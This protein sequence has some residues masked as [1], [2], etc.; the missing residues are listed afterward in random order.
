MLFG[1]SHYAHGELREGEL[2]FLDGLNNGFVLTGKSIRV[3]ASSTCDLAMRWMPE[4]SVLKWLVWLFIGIPIA[5][6]ITIVI[7]LIWAIVLVAKLLFVRAPFLYHIGLLVAIATDLAILK[8][9]SIGE[10]NVAPSET[11]SI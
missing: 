8:A 1:D 10:A 2:T 7:S 9:M 5:F 3:A 6:L 4:G 11:E